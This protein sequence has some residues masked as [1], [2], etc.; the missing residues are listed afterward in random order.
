MVVRGEEQAMR[1]AIAASEQVR[2]T[3]SPNPPVGCVILGA[4]GEVVGVGA[5]RPPGGPHAEVVALRAAGE[6][7]EGG[8]AVVTL[9]PC[10]H[11]GRTPP[12]TDAL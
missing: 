12:C 10:S 2:G 11:T 8:T 9:E 7:A 3:T 6:R 5:T 4:G 1:A